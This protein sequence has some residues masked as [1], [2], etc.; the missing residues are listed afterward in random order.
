MKA[1]T[2]L[3]RVSD[4]SEKIASLLDPIDKKLIEILDDDCAHVCLQGGD[5]IVI[6][7]GGGFHNA[8]IE[9]S[10]IDQLLKMSKKKALD[11]LDRNTI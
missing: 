8:K 2:A 9:P 6:A 5:G 1:S 11:F 10:E 3:K 4:H 7:Y